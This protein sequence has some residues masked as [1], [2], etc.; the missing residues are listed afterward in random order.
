MLVHSSDE[1]QLAHATQQ[2]RVLYSFN[3][4]DFCRIHAEWLAAGKSHSGMLLGH[5]RKRYPVG[6]QLR[7]LLK[8]SAHFETADMRDRLEYLRDW[9]V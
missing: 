5:Q 6:T 2:S 1:T 7:A 4:A 8:L 9:V 3:V